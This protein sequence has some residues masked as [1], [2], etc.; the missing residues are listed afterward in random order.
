MNTTNHTPEESLG[1]ALVAPGQHPHY[2]E[3]V[4]LAD[5]ERLKQVHGKRGWKKGVRAFCEFD[6]DSKDECQGRLVFAQPLLSRRIVV[7][8]CVHAAL[9]FVGAKVMTSEAVQAMP[10]QGQQAYYEEAI[11]QA[12]DTI[13]DQVD[14]LLAGKYPQE[15]A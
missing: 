4:L 12:T 10:D 8:E 9:I 13:F 6:H 11:P 5:A 7:H 1:R 2:F 15:P 14:R 3:V